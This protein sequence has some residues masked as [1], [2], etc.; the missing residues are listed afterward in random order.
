MPD[1][2]SII[3]STQLIFERLKHKN[4]TLVKSPDEHDNDVL[5]TCINSVMQ[6]LDQILNP[7]AHR[8]SEKGGFGQLIKAYA[9]TELGIADKENMLYRFAAEYMNHAGDYNVCILFTSSEARSRESY[10]LIALSEQPIQAIMPSINSAPTSLA[11]YIRKLPMKTIIVDPYDFSFVRKQGYII[12]EFNKLIL[13]PNYKSVA[14]RLDVELKNVFSSGNNL[15]YLMQNL[16]LKKMLDGCAR[17]LDCNTKWRHNQDNGNFYFKYTD[18]EVNVTRIAAK[19]MRDYFKKH[20]IQLIVRSNSDGKKN[21][22]LKPVSVKLFR[23]AVIKCHLTLDIDARRLI[24]KEILDAERIKNNATT[25]NVSGNF[26]GVSSNHSATFN[27]KTGLSDI[28]RMTTI[29]KLK[30]PTSLGVR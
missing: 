18:E 21:L 1:I 30:S 28:D 19:I 29:N 4:I 9:L 25:I 13:A 5:Q 2:T 3:D 8:I 10:P 16:E 20:G 12:S 15:I 22:V 7:Y 17:L 24:P 14:A 27:L 11:D 6:Q 23:I 26:S